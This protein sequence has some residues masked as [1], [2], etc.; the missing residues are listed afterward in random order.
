M[1]I[2]IRRIW[3]AV[4]FFGLAY[5]LFAAI[6]AYSMLFQPSGNIEE[7][8]WRVI[9][10]TVLGLAV[11]GYRMR[12]YQRSQATTPYNQVADQLLPSAEEF[13]LIL[14]PFGRDGDTLLRSYKMTKKMR[15]RTSQLPYAD[16]ITMEQVI[17]R[18]A[19]RALGHKTYALVDQ[20]RKIAPPGPVYVRA[21]DA[22]WQAAVLP[23]IQ[24]AHSVILWLPPG[25]KLRGSFN[26]EIEQIVQSG[27][28]HRTIIVLP[29][30]D[31]QIDS[32]RE[33]V[34]QAALLVSTMETASGRT[35]EADEEKIRCYA[36]ELGDKTIA[37]RL[38]AAKGEASKVLMR[39]FVMEPGRRWRFWRSRVDASLYENGLADLLT[40][41]E[42]DLAGEPL[43]CRYP[44]LEIIRRDS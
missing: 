3:R 20:K 27:L 31:Q 1:A 8:G 25:Q 4:G 44:S 43:L 23:F 40:D 9:V 10:L 2:I 21:P 5:T 33:A 22:D 19:Q 17:S 13:C 37:M 18:S 12:G 38:E 36:G 35:S 11:L 28:Q 24:R 26:W 30:P 6:V 41:I 16:I 34:G 39:W 15:R 14:R 32:Y 7:S 42:K 29:P